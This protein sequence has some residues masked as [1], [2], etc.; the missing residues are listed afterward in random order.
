MTIFFLEESYLQ[1]KI[2]SPVS[3]D[4]PQNYFHLTLNSELDPVLTDFATC[5]GS[6]AALDPVVFD[7]W[8][9]A[10]IP[11][12]YG[13][14]WHKVVYAG[15]S[16]GYVA[17]A[18][19]SNDSAAPGMVMTS[20]DGVTWVL[21]TT[22]DGGLRFWECIIYVPSSGLLVAGTQNKDG[23]NLVTS[24]DG[25]TWT[26]GTT[27]VISGS[28]PTVKD[29]VWSEDK[30]MYAGVGGFTGR[31][32][33]S[34]DLVTWNTGTAT[35]YIDSPNAI[36]YASSLGIFVA[37]DIYGIVYTS[38]DGIAWT[39]LMLGGG[40]W[41]SL[42]DSIAWSESLGMLVAFGE[43][44]ENFT[45]PHPFISSPDGVTWTQRD[46]GV[47]LTQ[48]DESSPG[49]YYYF[50][51]SYS[52]RWDSN[53][54]RFYAVTSGDNNA[55]GSLML[56]SMY[57]T[58]SVDGI[59]WTTDSTVP[60]THNYTYPVFLNSKFRDVAFADSTN[61]VLLSEYAVAYYTGV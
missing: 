5:L 24:L 4:Y 61:R 42:W 34:S 21:Q 18:I 37:I 53:T 29:I 26:L 38:T 43:A 13:H 41:D 44:H 1:D 11:T 39:F 16:I 10:D 22:P 32:F 12:Q 50:M 14:N 7:G 57:L 46:Y 20:L 28:V 58:E 36:T 60:G 45:Q 49:V 27:G 47:T 3:T 15:P 52:I 9:I 56:P 2:A 33:S 48:F 55:P 25:V 59:N 17:V 40:N 30:A 23:Y 8:D 35:P 54:S 6:S 19:D 31:I 51:P